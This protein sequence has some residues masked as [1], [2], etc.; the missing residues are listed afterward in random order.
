MT[1]PNPE[2]QSRAT[3]HESS[4]ESRFRKLLH[5]A[6][7]AILE[8]NEEGRILIVNEAVE[9]MFGYSRAELLGVS[10]D[11]LV[12]ASMGGGHAQH[13]GAY[14]EHRKARPM[15]TGLELQG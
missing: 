11:Q 9:R 3:H 2:A 6:P 15:G 7:D 5:A 8:V 12:P 10:V 4:M 13:R 14:A 1:A